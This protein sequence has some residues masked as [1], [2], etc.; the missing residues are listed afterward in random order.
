[1]PARAIRRGMRVLAAAVTMAA[2]ACAN[3]SY[4]PRGDGGRVTMTMSGGEI[5]ATRNGVPMGFARAVADNRAAEEHARTA[6]RHTIAA[7]LLIIA[8][9]LAIGGGAAWASSA[10]GGDVDDGRKTQ[11]TLLVASGVIGSIVGGVFASSAHAHQLDAVNIYNDGLPLPRA[12]HVPSAP[13]RTPAPAVTP[14]LE[15]T[16]TPLDVPAESP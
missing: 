7:F 12:T 14:F 16:V 6:R 10:E 2:F 13:V 4:V 8:G 15:P 1:M 3:T 11:G 5:L 9:G